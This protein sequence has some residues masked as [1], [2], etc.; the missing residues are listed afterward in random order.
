M[1]PT[2]YHYVHCPFCVRV[3]MSLGFLGIEYRSIVVSYDDE[4]T[5]NDLIGKKMLPIMVINGSAM[6][7][8]LDII[9]SLDKEN[10]L[11]ISGLKT[12]RSFKEFEGLMNE[13]GS[14]VHSLAMPF[15]IYS[16]EFNEA[17]R[18]YFQTKKEL[19]RGP[20]RELLKNQKEFVEKINPIIKNLENN[21][22]F[23]Y[24]SDTLSIKDIMI[25]AH[26]WG[27]YS[28][29]EFQFSPKIHLYLQSVKD[30]CHFIYHEPFWEFI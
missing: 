7:E 29:P 20:F 16:P 8:S 2:L 23:F 19:K 10:I 11:N 28:V 3:R 22:N 24:E 14:L 30:K 1:T 15:W 26:L 21:L 12:E 4:K 17:S 6:G 5:P 13:V 27:L 18:A 25:S 9:S